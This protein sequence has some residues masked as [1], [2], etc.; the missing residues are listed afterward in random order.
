[1]LWNV[2]T[3]SIE[4]CER[5][6]PFEDFTPCLG[7][8]GDEETIGVPLCGLLAAAGGLKGV[9]A[10]TIN[11]SKKEV[12]NALETIST[13]QYQERVLNGDY[14]F[15]KLD[16]VL[17]LLWWRPPTY[18]SEKVHVVWSV[19]INGPRRLNLSK[20]TILAH[21]LI[22]RRYPSS[23]MLDT[24]GS[25]TRRPVLESNV[26]KVRNFNFQRSDGQNL[27]CELDV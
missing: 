6:F 15:G 16:Y 21:C 24:F 22:N 20:S 25:P 12:S 2:P 27:L 19:A 13:T 26:W 23:N 3:W 1:M 10:P 7:N 9:E 18:L 4:D 14:C 17:S 8:N 5:V 11:L